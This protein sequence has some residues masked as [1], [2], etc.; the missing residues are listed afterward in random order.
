[1]WEMGKGGPTRHETPTTR[2]GDD[3]SIA[4]T[5]VLVLK[6]DSGPNKSTPS[7]LPRR[8]FPVHTGTKG[9]Q[10]GHHHEPSTSRTPTANFSSRVA[11]PT[12]NLAT[13]PRALYIF[14]WWHVFPCNVGAYILCVAVIPHLTQLRCRVRSTPRCCFVMPARHV[15]NEE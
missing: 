2:E 15:G 9:N 14:Y 1:M 11:F 12:S 8:P 5:F 13:Q 3:P 7:T 4:E 10:D 6:N